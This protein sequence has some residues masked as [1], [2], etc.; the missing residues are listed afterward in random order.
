[1]ALLEAD[2]PACV[3]SA[4]ANPG[5]SEDL[6][7]HTS[8]HEAAASMTLSRDDECLAERDAALRLYA[9]T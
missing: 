6:A 1:M 4:A 9:C 3:R 7:G 2:P 8:P 5:P